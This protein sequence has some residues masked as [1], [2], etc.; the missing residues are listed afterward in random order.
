VFSIH[1]SIKY[2]IKSLND[3][4]INCKSLQK[5]C[6]ITKWPPFFPNYLPVT[7]ICESLCIR[8]DI[9]VWHILNKWS[10]V[11]ASNFSFVPKVT[12]EYKFDCYM[13]NFIWHAFFNITLLSIVDANIIMRDLI[14]GLYRS[15]V[16][17]A[18]MLK[19][20]CNFP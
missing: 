5:G 16:D 13:M 12:V 15:M 4:L 1:N 3:E 8:T 19:K 17:I 20:S 10:P 14:E 11:L 2:A 7:V 18:M 6:S 9:P